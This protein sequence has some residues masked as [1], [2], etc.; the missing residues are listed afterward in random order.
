MENK[1][2]SNLLRFKSLY[3]TANVFRNIRRSTEEEYKCVLDEINK[4]RSL[5]EVMLGEYFPKTIEKMCNI[6]VEYRP[7]EDSSIK[8]LI[9]W[10]SYLLENYAELI[11]NYIDCKNLY[12][13]AL[14]NE[15]YSRALYYLEKVEKEITVSLWGKQQEFLVLN[16]QN[17]ERRIN[18]I[19]NKIE[20]DVSTSIAALLMHFYSKMTN[21][22]ITYE[23]YLEIINNLL[24]SSDNTN[25]IWKYLDYKLS[26]EKTKD[27]HGIKIALV[28]DEQVSIIDYFETYVDALIILS[29]NDKYRHLIAEVLNRLYGK[30]KDNRIE[31]MYC[32]FVDV[33][34]QNLDL[35]VCKAIECYTRGQ[36]DELK[37]IWSRN[38]VKFISDYTMSSVFVKA[39]IDLTK[40]SGFMSDFWKE[41]QKMYS[42]EHEI[43]ISVQRICESYKLLYNTSWRYKLQGVMSRKLNMNFGENVFQYSMLTDKFFTP[44]FHRCILEQERKLNYIKNFEKYTSATYQLQMYLITGDVNKELFNDVEKNRRSYYEIKYNFERKRYNDCIDTINVVKKEDKLSGYERER[45]NRILFECFLRTQNYVEAMQLYVNAY[46]FNVMQIA[47]MNILELVNSIEETEDEKIKSNV[48]RSI[49]LFLYYE[50]RSEGV[51]ASYLDYLELN[52]C[53]TIIDYL[54]KYSELNDYQTLFLEKVCSIKLLLKDYVS[55]TLTQGSAIDL[56]V[57]I[58]EKLIKVGTGNTKRFVNELNSIYKDQQL[59]KRIDSF[60]HNRIFID[61][62][63]LIAYLKD[64]IT[65]EFDRYNIVQEIRMLTKENKIG[66]VNKEFM[67]EN[68]WD[69]TKFFEKIVEK[70]KAA[71]LSESPYSLESFLST[72]IRHNFC[73]DKLK[74]IFEEQ[75]LFSKKEMDSS[76]E[77]NINV[78]WQNKMKIDEYE[79]L[80]PELSNFS[81]KIDAKIQE[82]KSNW[83]R[84][85]KDEHKEGMFDYVQFTYKFMNY[86]LLDYGM[87]LDNP[88]EFVREV[89]NELDKRTSEILGMIRKR[90]SKEIR[91]YYYHNIIDLENRIKLLQISGKNKAELLRHIEITKAKYIESIEAFED[92]FY[93]DNGKYPDY[94]F[95]ELIDFCIK[96]ESDM[97]KEFPNANLSINNH[98]NNC[99]QGSTFPYMVDVIEILLRNAV[100]HSKIKDMNKLNIK[101]NMNRI[102]EI[103]LKGKSENII[104]KYLSK[105]N[106]IVINVCN[107]LDGCVDERENL[108]RVKEIVNNITNKTYRS[109]SNS[110]GGSGLYKIAKTVEYNLGT[111][112]AIYNIPKE[113]YFDIFLVID[114]EKYEV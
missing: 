62:E 39:G 71:Y 11:N 103:T 50:G 43:R 86:V 63:N 94:N 41:I 60:N 95:D 48:C 87:L 53:N 80:K 78:Y 107:N 98:C 65:R 34:V 61:R 42:L 104:K 25:V 19:L 84:I 52:N 45:I 4:E 8:Q 100:Q 85:K 66:F 76:Q 70:I 10:G 110:E 111:K 82:I 47:R 3:P 22:H 14:F 49:I 79:V 37:T 73:N 90:I 57:K 15:K 28:V 30:I 33:A 67:M 32:A 58:L 106:A 29:S 16:F 2:I 51:I 7:R 5:K 1:T 77:Y 102:S 44:I 97:N 109:Y 108:E 92:I 12:E 101:I 55:K 105:E 69:Q 93:M 88:M 74:K 35:E 17:D 75:N 46:M 54:N 40:D 26:I 24:N 112:A 9:I 83:I 96:I 18:S 113:H 99:Y 91:P 36:Y 68:Y 72:R 38:R 81:S 59:K 31:C 89:I 21:H 27:I 23:K 56:R 20:N 64:E 114:L 6:K 13:E